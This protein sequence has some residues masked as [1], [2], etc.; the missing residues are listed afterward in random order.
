MKSIFKSFLLTVATVA[1]LSACSSDDYD[2]PAPNISPE[3]L[4]EGIAFTVTPD[5]SNPNLIHLKSLLP[6]SYQVAWE[7]PQGRSVGAE[8]DLKIPFDGDYEVKIGV[9]TRGG[10]VWSNPAK[11]TISD[12]C[13]DFVAGE[14]WEFLAGGAGNSKTWVPDN[15]QYGMK[16]GFYSCL[17]PSAVHADMIL[18]DGTAGDWYADG[19]T[20][21][22]PKYPE[23]G[24]DN[25]EADML[26]EMTFSLQGNA[27]VS[28]SFGNGITPAE[29]QGIFNFDPDNMTISLEGAQIYHGFWA[30]GLSEDWSKNLQVL[31]LTE[32]Q[33]M[34]GNYRSESLSGE[35]ACIYCWNFVS[36][37]YAENYV[38]GEVAEPE[39]TLPDGWKEDISQTVITSV[40]W[41]LS[42][43]NPLDWCNLDG[44]FMNGWNSPSDYPDWLGTPDPAVYGD[45]SM[46]LDSKDNSAVF[47]YP[48]GSKVETTYELDDKG[49]Y[50]F[51]DA[52]PSTTVVGWA[53]FALD[54]NNGLR[55]LNIEK[56]GFGNVVGMWLGQRSTE[57]DEYL[58]FHFTPQAGASGDKPKVYA[59][60]LNW[61]NTGDWTGVTGEIVS[62]SGEGTYTA[63]VNATWT[64]GDPLLWLQVD[65]ILADN[66]NADVEILNIKVDGNDVTFDDSAISRGYP[67]DDAS[68]KSF[69]R[70]ICNA[71]GLASCFPSLDIFKMQSSTE[72]TFK[73]TYD[74]GHPAF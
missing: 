13:A 14:V 22:E 73:V 45:F 52:V 26:G 27:A 34:I 46:T 29:Q 8:R 1:G 43:Q 50:T 37:E 21:W 5:A 12:F 20:W 71:W 59:A 9:S 17:D 40:K 42:D 64:A 58:A 57:K 68:T 66:P 44:S 54:S 33:L 62:I 6:A 4:V 48:D 35:G 69:R 2:L 63:T 24:G 51:S 61:N 47:A 74:I 36:K 55:I 32:N 30:H 49:I 41:V 10:Y 18:K 7:T 65:R 39:P 25:A 53:S 3:D 23:V 60:T 31:V 19:K 11:F 28:V 56:D 70:Y 15:G 16:Q 72:V 38:P 67:D